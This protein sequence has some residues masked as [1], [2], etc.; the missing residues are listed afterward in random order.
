M[1]L[2]WT[3]ECLTYMSAK[4]FTPSE[5]YNYVHQMVLYIRIFYLMLLY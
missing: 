5:I 1:E 3:S 4:K 2:L